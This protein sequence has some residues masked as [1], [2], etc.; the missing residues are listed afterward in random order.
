MPFSKVGF[1]PEFSGLVFQQSYTENW[2]IKENLEMS[3]QE[4]RKTRNLVTGYKKKLES[5]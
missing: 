5:Y 2:R 1:S 3:E 4:F